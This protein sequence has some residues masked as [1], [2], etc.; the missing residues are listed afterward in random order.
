MIKNFLTSMLE[1]EK[2][3]DNIFNSLNNYPLSSDLM[4]C[5]NSELGAY[6]LLSTLLAFDAI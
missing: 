6:S 1:I 2:V 3:P 5:Y 4:P